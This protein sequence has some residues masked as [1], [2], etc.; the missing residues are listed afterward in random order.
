MHARSKFPS[1]FRVSLK[2]LRNRTLSL[3]FKKQTRTP[4]NAKVPQ[5]TLGTIGE[6]LTR[7]AVNIAVLSG[8]CRTLQYCSF[9][10]KSYSVQVLKLAGWHRLQTARTGNVDRQ[11]R[12]TVSLTLNK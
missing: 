3:G 2:T 1:D 11:P 5:V 8:P 6:P 10:N 7:L 9:L 12:A 4:I